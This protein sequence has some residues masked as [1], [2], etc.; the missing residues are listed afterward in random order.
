MVCTL[1]GVA[2]W[3]LNICN[4]VGCDHKLSSQFECDLW[5]LY[6]KCK[7]QIGAPVQ[8]IVSHLPESLKLKDY[9]FKFIIKYRVMQ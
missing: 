2:G 1:L 9:I 7:I 4:R 6:Q 3:G 5:F 8:G